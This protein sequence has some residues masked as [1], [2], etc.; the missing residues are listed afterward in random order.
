[1]NRLAYIPVCLL[2]FL[3]SKDLVA[4]DPLT[5]Q[6]TI[7]SF[8]NDSIPV[9]GFDI[10]ERKVIVISRDSI[11]SKVEYGSVDSNYLDNVTRRVYLYGDAYV[12]YKDLSLKADYIVVDLDSSIAVA[13]GAQD[14]LGDL[15][16]LPVFNMAEETF[17]AERIRYNFKSRKG[18]IYNVVTE[19]GDLL[20]HGDKTKFVAATSEPGRGDNILYNE[21]ALITSCDLPHPH[22]GIRARKVKT[23]PDKLAVVGPSHL[24]LFGVPTPLW[25][26]FGFYPVSEKRR[27][28]VIFPRDYERS[29]QWGFGLKELGYYFPIKDWADIKLT[30]DIYFNGSWGLGVSS[31]YLRKYKYRGNITL[32]VSDRITEASNSYK[33]TNQKS[34][35]IRITHNQDAK[36]HPYQNLGG[37]VNIQTNDYQSLNYND[38]ASVLNT[39]YT[40]NFNYSRI[41]PNKPYSLTA[42]FSHS[43]NTQSRIV[44]ISAPDLNF[45]LNRIYPFKSKNRPGPDRWYEKIAF[46]YSGQGKAK[47]IGTD[48]T[49]FEKETLEKAQWGTQHRAS[50]STNFSV[51]KYFN[52]TPSIDYGETWFF[53]TSVDTFLFDPNDTNFVKP[54]TILFPDGTISHIEFDTVNNGIIEKRLE[55]G[56]TPFRSFSGSVNMN[57]QIFGMLEFKKGWLRGIRH[58]IKPNIGFSYA[59]KSPGNYYKQSHFSVAFPDSLRQYSRFDNLLFSTRPVD[60]DQALLNYSFTNLFEAKYFSKRDSTEKKLKLFD[61]ISVGG[62][63]NMAKVDSFRFSPVNISGNTRLFKGLTTIS[64]GAVYSFYGLRENGRLDPTFYIESHNKLLRFD[65]LRL[66]FSTQITLEELFGFFNNKI[67]PGSSRPEI[68]AENQPGRLPESGDKLFDLLNNLAINHELGVVLVGMT[69]RDTTVITTHSINMV[70][71]IRLTP[72]WSVRFGNI[73]YDFR[74]KQLTYPDIGLARDLHC[75]ELAFSFQPDRGTYSFHIGVK[76]GTF[77]FLKF[78]YRRNNQDAF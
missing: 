57:T 12:R 2:A 59:P 44:E 7:D 49:L 66:R 14:S 28:G 38:A 67:K 11:D 76:P 32:G 55:N 18:F 54:D 75:W 8:P 31:N 53:K 34:Y 63:Y 48:T 45:R 43:Q 10:I 69:G 13:E 6:F 47:L 17:T 37:S 65:N 5:I 30:G 22:F 78:P 62:N 15:V 61:N 3:F 42:G 52:F 77:D 1:M 39:I 35:T 50:A 41:F 9:D 74:S 60:R 58:V 25:L 21:G 71:N 56:F 20:I 26:P 46:Q 73:G 23:I 19:E 27:A 33:E 36:A 68:S 4:Q 72:N 70:G 16:G 24:E 40:S 29:P 64:V 51:L